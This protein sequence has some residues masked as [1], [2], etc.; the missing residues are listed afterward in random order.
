MLSEYNFYSAKQG[1]KCL[2]QTPLSRSRHNNTLKQ[3]MVFDDKKF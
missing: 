2:I 1:N 3:T